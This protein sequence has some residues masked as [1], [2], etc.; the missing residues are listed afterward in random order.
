MKLKIYK[1]FFIILIF[2]V[3]IV[4]GLICLKNYRS[5]L[6]DLENEKVVQTFMES[7]EPNLNED[8]N[9][10]ETTKIEDVTMNG[11]KVVGVIKIPKIDIKYPILDVESNSPAD[12]E[13]PMKTSIVKY[14]GR[15][16]K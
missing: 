6:T 12:T 7:L 15:E 10:E 2:A 8:N 13:K 4:V 16:R 5:Y 11:Y 14:W 9:I 3:F 1:I